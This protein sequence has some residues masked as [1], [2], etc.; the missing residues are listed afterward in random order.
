MDYRFSFL[1]PQRSFARNLLMHSFHFILSLLMRPPNPFA[2]AKRFLR[3]AGLERFVTTVDGKRA[4]LPTQPPIRD[5][6]CGFK[7]LTRASAAAIFPL[8]HIDRWIFD[9]ELLLLAEMASSATLSADPAAAARAADAIE[10]EG[11]PDPLLWLPLPIS[12]VAVDWKEVAGSKI[13]ILKDSVKMGL[14]LVVI[15]LNY[16]LGRWRRPAPLQTAPRCCGES[17]AR[18]HNGSAAA[19]VDDVQSC[20]S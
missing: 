2:I 12:E 16:A 7:L 19:A 9:V 18:K 10:A 17:L 6:Q 3:A 4:S 14:D 1:V 8:A 13:D 11:A 15:R 5:T 20:C